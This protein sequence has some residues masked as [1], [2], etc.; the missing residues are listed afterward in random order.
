MFFSAVQCQHRTATQQRTDEGNCSGMN[1]R[2]RAKAYSKSGLCFLFMVVSSNQLHQSGTAEST[3]GFYILN[4]T[5]GD[6]F[7]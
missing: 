5:A 4:F 3:N 6:F 7:L 2:L 1:T